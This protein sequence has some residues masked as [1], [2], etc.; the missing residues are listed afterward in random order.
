MYIFSTVLMVLLRCFLLT[1]FFLYIYNNIWYSSIPNIIYDFKLYYLLNIIFFILGSFFFFLTLQGPKILYITRP[2]NM[3]SRRGVQ[4]HLKTL[5]V[6]LGQLII[7]SGKLV[8]AKR[9]RSMKGDVSCHIAWKKFLI[10]F[11]EK[12]AGNG[13]LFWKRGT[14]RMG[15]E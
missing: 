5:R 3:V 1:L 6:N 11:L 2:I 8:K 13:G 9:I 4:W 15:M 10:L 14:S 12:K 7:I